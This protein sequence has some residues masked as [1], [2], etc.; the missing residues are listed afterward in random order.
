[1]FIK[2]F[3]G[4]FFS[5]TIASFDDAAT[6]IPIIAHLTQSRKG[7]IAFGIGNFFAVTIVIILTWF[8][9]SLLETIPYIHQISSALIFVLAGAVYF[10]LFGKRATT[11]V[12]K[13]EKKIV[14][15][16]SLAKFFRLIISG[17]IISFA[18]LIDD[19]MVLIPLFLGP[20]KS[21]FYVAAGIYSST[22]L[23]LIAMDYL[24][25]KMPQLHYI[26]EVAIAGLLVLALLVFLEIF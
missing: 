26:K 15:L 8:F 9:S 1:M 6:R 7:R 2:Y 14:E 16:I 25:K 13:Q 20:P 4:G 22:L 3:I 11:K 18:T 10:D 19:I 5:K 17:F 12:I 21:H 23:Q 24:T